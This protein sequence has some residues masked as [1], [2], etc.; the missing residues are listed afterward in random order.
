M[1]LV[2]DFG[3]NWQFNLTLERVEPPGKKMKAPRIVESHGACAEQYPSW[4]E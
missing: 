4:E 1:T 3:D 2:Y